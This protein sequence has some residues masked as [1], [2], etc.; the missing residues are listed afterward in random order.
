[1]TRPRFGQNLFQFSRDGCRNTNSGGVVNRQY[2][3]ITIRNYTVMY[4]LEYPSLPPH[5][6]ILHTWEL[7]ISD[8]ALLPSTQKHFRHFNGN[9]LVIITDPIS[10]DTHKWRA[11]LNTLLN[12]RAPYK[13]ANDK[14]SHYQLSKRV[15]FSW[16]S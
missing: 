15:L 6:E 1:V 2:V 8:S 7:L 4:T 16:V 3:R 10:P 12:W 11:L 14:M 13:A 9:N 5:S